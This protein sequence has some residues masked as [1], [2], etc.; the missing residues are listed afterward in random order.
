MKMA[1][2]AAKQFE[3]EN[4]AMLE[5]VWKACTSNA[6]FGGSPVWFWTPIRLLR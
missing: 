5:R 4:K 6:L 2:E 1:T 3:Q